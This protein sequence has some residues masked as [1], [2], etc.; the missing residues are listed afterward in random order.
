MFVEMDSELFE[1][2]QRQY[3]ERE[4]MAGELEEKRIMTWKRLEDAAAEVA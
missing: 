2:C 3:E 4:A 1:R